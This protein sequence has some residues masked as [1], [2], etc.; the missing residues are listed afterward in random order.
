MGAKAKTFDCVRFKRD[1]QRRLRE[2][3]ESRKDEFSSYIDFIK[4]K[5]QEDEW[6]RHLWKRFSKA[7]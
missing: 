6:S 3:F 5:V 1:A 2:E 7:R 4:A